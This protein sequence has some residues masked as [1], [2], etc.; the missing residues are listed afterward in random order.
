MVQL[1][2]FYMLCIVCLKL[3]CL[4][5]L[6]ICFNLWISFRRQIHFKHLLIAKRSEPA[7]NEYHFYFMLAEFTLSL[8]YGMYYTFVFSVKRD[9]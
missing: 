2:G 6:G 9:F 4:N 7:K 5:D 8:P 3:A 1:C